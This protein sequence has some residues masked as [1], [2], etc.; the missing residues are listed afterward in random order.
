MRTRIVGF[1][2]LTVALGLA[3]AGCGSATPYAAKVNGETITQK[4][5][6]DEMRSIALNDAYVKKVEQT[7]QVRGTGVGDFDVAFT[8]QVL[9]RQIQYVLVDAEITKRKIKILPADL[10]AARADVAQQAGGEDILNGFPKAYQDTL[11]ERAA[12]V[13]RLT[14]SLSGAQ[15]GDDAAKAYYEAHKDEF[16]EACVSHILLTTKE[17]ADQLK[18]KIAAGTDFATVARSDSRDT[19]SATQGGDLGCKINAD[20]FAVP[21]FIKAMLT[22]PIG[23]VGD[24]VQTKFGFHLILVRSRTVPP[25]DQVADRARDKVVTANK[26]RL[27]EWINST[28]AN[29]K[30]QVNPKYGTFNKQSYAVDPPVTTTV[31]TTT[32]TIPGIVP[33]QPK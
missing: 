20:S 24:P 10:Q 29:A 11:T 1:V 3:L 26:Q 16:T 8:G 5:L 6:E 15:G 19:S 28:V 22:Q 17:K 30:I 32:T 7:T 18:A 25:Y 14:L 33:L 23:Q 13:S 27:Q 31:P 21:E 2:A 4:Q 9:G 12:K